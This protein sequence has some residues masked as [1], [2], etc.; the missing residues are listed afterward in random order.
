MVRSTARQPTHL[1]YASTV[2]RSCYETTVKRSIG[3]DRGAVIAVFIEN[4]HPGL[5]AVEVR[6]VSL[7]VLRAGVKTAGNP[8]VE[9]EG[10]ESTARCAPRIASRGQDR[11]T[12]NS[13]NLY[14]QQHTSSPRPA[15]R[16]G[17]SGA[18]PAANT[19]RPT[20]AT[21]THRPGWEP[22]DNSEQNKKSGKPVIT[23]PSTAGRRPSPVQPPCGV[24][25][26]PCR[27]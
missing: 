13:M 25:W 17:A 20:G 21:Y 10:G 19:A 4:P 8:S 15:V 14:F 18:A 9:T 5:G 26:W 2:G 1:A 27:H 24:G 11:R 22:G 7:P 3:R 23:T 6:V 16:G 12:R